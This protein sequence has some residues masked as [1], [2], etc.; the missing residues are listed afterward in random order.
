MLE[1][2]KLKE[3]SGIQTHQQTLQKAKRD[4]LFHLTSLGYVFEQKGDYE[5]TYYWAIHPDYYLTEDEK[6]DR[7]DFV[8]DGT[9]SP[10][11]YPEGAFILINTVA[12]SETELWYETDYFLSDDRCYLDYLK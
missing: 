7:E 12:E 11:C 3:L 10:E 6:W 9:I 2:E 4:Y 5:S 1:R 8:I